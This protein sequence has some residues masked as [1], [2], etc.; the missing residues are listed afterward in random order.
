MFP[1]AT[2]SRAIQAIARR[3]GF[4]NANVRWE[5]RNSGRQLRDLSD[6]EVVAIVRNIDGHQLVIT[7]GDLRQEEIR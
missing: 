5:P 1:L 3:R 2:A 7:A 6:N 4:R